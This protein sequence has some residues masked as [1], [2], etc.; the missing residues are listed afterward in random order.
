V[1]Q[2]EHALRLG[3]LK[4]GDQLR[5]VKHVVAALT[6]N[7]NTVLKAYLQAPRAL[8]RADPPAAWHGRFR[9]SP[10]H[11]WSPAPSSSAPSS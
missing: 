9:C 11:G 4:P 10:R 2:V 6:I 1:Q 3:Y 7:P 5:K 8:A